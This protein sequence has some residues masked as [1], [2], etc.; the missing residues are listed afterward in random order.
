M[1]I[2]PTA[3]ARVRGAAD[4]AIVTEGVIADDRLHDAE[5]WIEEMQG[6]V[7]QK[8]DAD[9]NDSGRAVLPWGQGPSLLR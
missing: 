6:D 4:P 3:D 5:A 9:T 1:A 2:R 8:K 7:G